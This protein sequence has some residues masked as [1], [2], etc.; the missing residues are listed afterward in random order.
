MENYL[1]PTFVW[2]WLPPFHARWTQLHTEIRLTLPVAL[3]LGTALT[4]Y[5]P[6]SALVCSLLRVTRVTVFCLRTGLSLEILIVKAY[7]RVVLD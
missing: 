2:Q 5:V 3:E 4:E 7:L 6:Y 1:D